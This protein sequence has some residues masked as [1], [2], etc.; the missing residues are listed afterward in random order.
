MRLQRTIRDAAAT[1]VVSA[2]LI[3]GC[4]GET[5]EALLASAKGYLAKDD[6]Q[7]AVIQLKNVLQKSPSLAE[8]R[9]L[10]GKALLESDDVRGAEKELRKALELKYPADQVV[11][12]LAR[13]LASLGEFNKVT[14][15][16][17][18]A[19]VATPEGKAELQTAIGQAH[20][21]MGKPSLASDAFSVALTAQ[22][23]YVPAL[24]GRALIAA[25]SRDLSGALATVD[26]ALAIAP[27]DQDAWQLKGNILLAQGQTDMALAAYRKAAEAKPSFLPAHSAIVLVLNQQGKVEDA[28]KQLESMKQV[29][30]SHPQTMYLQA[31][32]AYRQKKFAAARE[33]IQQ[34]LRVAPDYL[35]GVLLAGA[36]EYEL[37]SYAQAETHLLKVL[38]RAPD[39]R[40][41]RRILVTGYLR[42]GQPGKAL[43]ALKPVLDAIDKDSDMLALAGEV[44]MVNGE[45]AQ[46]AEYFAKAAALDPGSADKRTAL[47]LSHMAKGE[48]E[49]AFG[50]LEK[51][52]GVDSGIR[53]DL[54]LVAGYLQRRQYDKALAAIGTLEKKQPDNPL[55]DNLRGGALL[56][57]GDSSGARRSFERALEKSPTYFPAAANLARLDLADKK[58]D[59][60][61]QRFEALLSKDAKNLQAL[62]ALAELRA[63]TGGS[64]EDVVALIGKAVTASPTESAPR[65]A[66]IGHYL[67]AKDSKKAVAAAQDALAAIPDRPEILDAAGRA[68]QAA[69]E[70]NQAVAT[71]NKLAA[72]Q[73]GSPLPYLRMAE[74]QV[75]AKDKDSAMQSLRKALGIKPDLVEAQ[76]GII[77]LD[78]D[79]GRFQEAIAVARDVQKQ[80]PKQSAGFLFEGD[81]H[82]SKKQ[83]ADAAAAYRNGLKQAGTPDLA[84][85]VHTALTAA[86]SN[87][88]A[89]T[90][91][92]N[93]LKDHQKDAVFRLHLAQMATAK[94]DYATAAQYYR[95]VVDDQPNN[96]LALNNLAWVAGQLKDP[97][98]LEYAELANKLTPN[99][100]AIMDTLGTLLVERGDTARGLE[101]LHKASELAPQAGSIRLN[102]AKGLIKVGKKEAAKKELDELAKLGEKFPDQ[103]EVEKLKQ[104]L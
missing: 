104:A 51:I 53:A 31:L 64:S 59:A 93:W 18:K 55:P 79:A 15:E 67:G 69:G 22:P 27:R 23:K 12:P 86:G 5:P 101:L 87:A 57:K 45:P 6:R 75:A 32:V 99:Q 49:R 77:A 80:R 10:L 37:K 52:A 84:V 94:K 58:P 89:S 42:S 73:P 90:F 46:A 3:S 88:D 50:E 83:W 24:L 56:G 33:A 17:A 98:A 76:R 100:P 85:R 38:Q 4:G 92:S 91:A 81:I 8:A 29:A 13:S 1:L 40:L 95:K 30:P 48:S 72:L 63:K 102:L 14:D 97:K 54:A 62:L 41:A 96:V 66:L 65:L 39:Q 19:E 28:A 61:R 70:T 47:A 68:L 34:Q 74:I 20:L 26:S 35:P 16:F 21:A 43:D 71:Y 103:G 25:G 2:M 7:A 11:P 44:Y 60:A 78:L 9:F 82:A 36:I